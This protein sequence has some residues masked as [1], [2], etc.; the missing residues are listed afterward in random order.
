MR[1]WGI[2]WKLIGLMLLGGVATIVAIGWISVTTGTEALLAQETNALEAIR[3]SRTRYIEKYFRTIREQIANFARNDMIAGATADFTAAFAAVADQTAR[4]GDP[5]SPA[6]RAIEAYYEREFRPRLE[7][8]GLS[9]QGS[10]HYLPASESARILQAMYIV[11]NPNPIG[12]KDRLDTTPD[13]CD[14]ARLH[15]HY[16]PRIREFLRSFG[17]YDIFLFDLSGNLVYS[18]FKETDF[19]TNVV[20][21]PYRGTHF[22]NVFLRA[23]GAESP[24]A[25]FIADFEPYEPSYGAPASFIGAPVFRDGVKVGAAVFQMPVDEINEIL[26]DTSGL[27]ATGET[28]L[29]GP[30]FMMRSDSRFGGDGSTVFRQRVTT[31]AAHRAL[32]GKTGTIEQADYRGVRVLSSFGPLDIIG[33]DWAML[34][35]IDMAELTAAAS[36]LRRRIALL[37]VVVGG[38]VGVLSVLLLRRIVIAPVQRLVRGAKH[39]EQGD[40]SKPVV[41]DSSDEL[42]ELATAFNHMTEAI[43]RDIEERQR[44]NEELLRAREAADQASRAK[45][46]FLSHMSHELRTPLNGV[47]G[48][49]QILQ[50]DPNVTPQQR[51]NLES[52]ESC[53]QHLLTLINDVLD[54]SKIE[55]GRLEIDH[56]PC[57]LHKLLKGVQD[58]VSPRAEAKGLEFALDVSPEVPR[59][60]VTDATKLKQI[61]VNMLGNSV[62][63]TDEGRVSLRVSENDEQQLEF[64][65]HDTG[66]GMTPEELAE[67]F[68]PFKQAEGGKTS[69][70][71]GLGLAISKRIIEALGGTITAESVRGSG[72]CFTITHPLEEVEEEAVATLTEETLSDKGLWALAPGQSINILVVDDR[73]ANRDI[74]CQLLESAGFGTARAGDGAEALQCLRA[75]GFPLVLMDVRMEGMNGIEATQEIRKD[76]DLKDTV[77]IAV[78]ASVFPDFREKALSEG[79]DDFIAKPFRAAEVFAKIEQH[80]GAR[81]VDQARADAGGAEP[82]PA[83]AGEAETTLSP[84]LADEVARRLRDALKLRNLTAINALASELQAKPDG[85]E[86]CGRRVADLARSFDFTGLARLA[87]ELA[88]SG[89][90]TS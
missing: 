12:E 81:F 9:W 7:A 10:P 79:F 13:E 14:Y 37:A 41:I 3:T 71:T 46:D 67:I 19:A 62:K 20:D 27:G 90:E 33:L 22:A 53:G 55:A 5:D 63:F 32:A 49:A 30:D 82:A 29:I 61:L 65:V 39:V 59:G 47:L 77:V 78:T 18:V 25:I 23:R 83:P 16:H 31:R 21:G 84:E 56:K 4:A 50:R 58:I 44:A 1:H 17:Y 54:L 74:L 80:I 87:D 68:D 70:G 69:G 2:A 43:A 35:E 72:S 52:I 40:F 34:A 36:V 66:I 76:P 42:G 60:I 28:Y 26:N 38:I 51:V 15:A 85:A 86:P 48:Y 24:G 88:P 8:A 64:A 89:Q 11:E 45:G 6:Y 57:D 73:A 75:D